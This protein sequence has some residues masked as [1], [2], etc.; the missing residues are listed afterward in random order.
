MKVAEFM[1]IFEGPGG[2]G[3][4]QSLQHLDIYD[5]EKII[6]YWP[7][8]NKDCWESGSTVCQPGGIEG[9]VE[10]WRQVGK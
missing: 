7:R 9:R 5:S 4:C 1:N 8:E 10:G 6:G 3:R 2:N